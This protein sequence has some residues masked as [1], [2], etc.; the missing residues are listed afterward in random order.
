MTHRSAYAYTL[1]LG[2]VFCLG[3]ATTGCS[4]WTE[5]KAGESATESP[6]GTNATAVFEPV[7]AVL[8][9]IAVSQNGSPIAPASDLERRVLDS[10]ADTHLFSHVAYPSSDAGA[11]VAPHV[12]AKLSVALFPEP[13]AG[14]AAW[15][16]IVIGAS[17]F[18][19][20]PVLPLE[21]EYGA[22]M[23]L[24][25]EHHNGTTHR[26]IAIAEGTAH[27]HLFGATHLAADE[28]K[29][30]IL[31]SCL[32]QLQ[33]EL[34]KDRLFVQAGY[35]ARSSPDQKR[36]GEFTAIPTTA[37]APRPTRTLSIL[38]STVP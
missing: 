19:L 6:S 36:P 33:R 22:R 8:T 27:Y 25:L 2:S 12:R 32:N 24:D 11:S 35:L 23:T 10:L 29:A 21:Y 34:V 28:L 18:L 15:K 13:H 7:P 37:P 1:L 17:M 30:Q 4:R 5:V 3:L 14:A 31:E 9:A 20:A 16:G 38:R 26:Y